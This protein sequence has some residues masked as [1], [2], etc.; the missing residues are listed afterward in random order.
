MKA[1]DHIESPLEAYHTCTHF[2]TITIPSCMNRKG[3][4]RQKEYMDR[5][6]KHLGDNFFEFFYGC[7]EFSQ[8]SNLH[9]HIVALPRDL[10]P[11][12]VFT[13]GEVEKRATLIKLNAQLRTRSIV[14]IQLIKN[15]DN[16]FKYINK[17]VEITKA[18][19]NK[20][21]FLRYRLKLPIFT[22]LDI[23]Q[24]L[25][26]DTSCLDSLISFNNEY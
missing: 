17:D 9:A 7:Y 12:L 5:Y 2:I 18:V 21:P 1:L 19:L 6:L 3:P 22:P 14:D 13:N 4:I 16:V 26:P 15:T 11:N 23:T 25:S 24:V 10:F 20:S 8:K